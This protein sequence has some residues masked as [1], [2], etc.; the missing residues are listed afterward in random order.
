MYSFIT[1]AILGLGLTTASAEPLDPDQTATVEGLYRLCKRHD[2]SKAFTFCVA[3]LAGVA[4]TLRM[5][6]I[7]GAKIFS[8]CG[9]P[10][11]G[12]TVQAFVDWAEANPSEWQDGRSVGVITALSKKWPCR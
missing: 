3:Y 12:D 2:E 11:Y 8:I 10:T 4:E 6:G 1:A 5:Q 9:T 7:G